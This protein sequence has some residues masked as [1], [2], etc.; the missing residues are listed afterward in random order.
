MDHLKE[1]IGLAGYG[2]RDPLIEYKREA[3]GAF[4]T[5]LAEIKDDIAHFILNT[6]VQARPT[7]PSRMSYSGASGGAA[8]SRRPSRKG[9]TKVGRNA[10]CPC[11][12]GAKFKHCCGK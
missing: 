5:L 11:G 10:P 2:Q 3:F 12:S 7:V 1:G 9:K 4:E 6:P 8:G